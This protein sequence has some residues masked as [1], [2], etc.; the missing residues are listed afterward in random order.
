MHTAEEGR[1][2]PGPQSSRV[3]P[4]RAQ[5]SITGIGVSAASQTCCV[6]LLDLSG[7]QFS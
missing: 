3:L 4:P 5:H 7:P 6:I 2:A 1:M